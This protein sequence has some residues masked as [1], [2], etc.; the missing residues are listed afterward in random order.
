MAAKAGALAAAAAR[1]SARSCSHQRK[2]S[3]KSSISAMRSAGNASIFSIRVLLSAGMNVPSKRLLVASYQD[4]LPLPIPRPV[5]RH[6]AIEFL[7]KVV[8]LRLAL[9]V[10]MVPKGPTAHPWVCLVSGGDTI[11]VARSGHVPSTQS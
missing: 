11:D 3:T 4:A 8:H 2:K 9:C 5:S 10:P 6:E 1:V 7:D